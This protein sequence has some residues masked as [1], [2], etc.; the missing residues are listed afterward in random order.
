MPTRF[1]QYDSRSKVQK[2]HSI[3]KDALSEVLRL[4]GVSTGA[5]PSVL[6]SL[7]NTITCHAIA[8]ILE[9]LPK[10]KASSLA[11]LISVQSV[12]TAALTRWIERE[13]IFSDPAIQ[14][15]VGRAVDVAMDNAANTLGPILAANSKLVYAPNR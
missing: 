9:T 4:A 7:K 8:A 13:G 14:K 5:I 10:E 12:D 1:S 11:R 2:S 6:E 3:N 15:A